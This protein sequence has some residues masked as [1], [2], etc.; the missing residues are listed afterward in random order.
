VT[1]V[2]HLPAPSQ[3]AVRVRVL[4]LQLS[5][6][7]VV[8][9]DHGRHAPPPLQVPS[10]EQSP[11][12]AAL[13]WQRDF[14][15][16]PPLSTL[17]Q[18]PTGL[19]RVP[20]HVLHRLLV[21]GSVQE[22]LQQTPSVQIPLWHWRASLQAAPLAFKPQ[23]LLMHVLGGV[24]SVASVADVQLDLHAPLAQAKTP[25]G[26]TAGVRQAPLPS[27]VEAGVSEDEVAQTAA[28]QLRPA[29]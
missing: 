22:E 28:A 11:L 8:S 29:S 13:A 3:V 24:Q 26:C 2:G 15:S 12:A 25:Q 19:R 4:P 16:P 6:R 1:A 5:G 20:L 10:F 17:A 27:Q 21:G 7:H 23:E 14:G 9:A 18:V